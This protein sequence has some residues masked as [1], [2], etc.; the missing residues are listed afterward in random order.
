MS[1]PEFYVAK[2]GATFDYQGGPVFLVGGQTIVRAGH[3]IM[4]GREHL[5][6][7][8]NIHYDHRPEPAEEKEAPAEHKSAPVNPV[9]AD[10]RGA[11][12]RTSHP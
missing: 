11:R 12:T 1:A 7:P 4:N 8:L 9:R 10:Q 5:F 3:P 6:V 2:E